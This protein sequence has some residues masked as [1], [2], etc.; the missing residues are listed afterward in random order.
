MPV[1]IQVFMLVVIILLSIYAIVLCKQL[2]TLKR[3]ESIDKNKELQRVENKKRETQESIHILVRCLLQD[4]VSLT[5]AA[6]RVSGLAKVLKLSEVEQQFYIAFDNLAMATS[7]IP[8]LADWGKLSAKEQKRFN[9]EREIIEGE[10]KNKVLDAAKRLS[11]P[12]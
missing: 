4:Q 11:Q 9:D 10:H 1:Y 6:I 12:Q 5:E 7:H 8:I 2:W 3:N